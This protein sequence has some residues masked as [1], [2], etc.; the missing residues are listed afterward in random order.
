MVCCLVHL[1]TD[2]QDHLHCLE[3]PSNIVNGTV[4]RDLGFYYLKANTR[5]KS[6]AVALY[7]SSLQQWQPPNN[8]NFSMEC[9]ISPSYSTSHR[10]SREQVFV[11]HCPHALH[12]SDLNA[13]S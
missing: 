3:T 5:Q 4:Q 1:Q 10:Q 6:Y 12:T 11:C 8:L 13:L 2:A 7:S 9:I